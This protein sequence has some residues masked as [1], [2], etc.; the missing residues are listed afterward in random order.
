MILVRALN[1][2]GVARVLFKLHPAAWRASYFERIK[3][4]FDL[5]CDVVVDGNFHDYVR[6]SDFVIGPASSGTMPETLALG[7]PYYPITLK[8]HCVD[9]NSVRR[10]KAYEN[11]NVLIADLRDRRVPDLKDAIPYLLGD[12]TPEQ[13]ADRLWRAIEESVMAMPRT[14][15]TPLRSAS[16]S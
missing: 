7:R 8:P 4:H 10:L 9:K 12:I 16:T 3:E 13:S 6:D 1:A 11:L 5:K 14:I 15:E 2:L